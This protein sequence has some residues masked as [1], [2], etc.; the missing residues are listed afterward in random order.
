MLHLSSLAFLSP[1]CASVCG[2]LISLE[3]FKLC[4]WKKLKVLF[5]LQQFSKL[6]ILDIS[7]RTFLKSVV[8]LESLV[9]FKRLN[10]QKCKGLG[11]LEYEKLQTE[12]RRES[13][14]VQLRF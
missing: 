5:D 4:L 14:V 9:A 13:Q 10:S 3:V 12:L 8:G 1:K 2:M 7:W 6:G 11:A